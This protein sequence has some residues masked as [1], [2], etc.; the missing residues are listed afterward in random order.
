[1]Q[2]S[3]SAFLNLYMPLVNEF[4][5]FTVL[6]L[7][8]LSFMNSTGYMSLC[9][10]IYS[11]TYQIIQ[12]NGYFWTPGYAGL[13]GK[14]DKWRMIQ[15]TFWAGL[16]FLANSFIPYA[17]NG[18]RKM[19]KLKKRSAQLWVVVSSTFIIKLQHWNFSKSFKRFV[20]VFWYPV[21]N[22]LNSWN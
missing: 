19:L 8:L 9:F 3:N 17:Y 22:K 12:Q 1:M 7:S 10:L 21:H 5:A 13:N 20:G 6:S 11:F 18:K 15:S 16:S 4:Y 14:L 2:S